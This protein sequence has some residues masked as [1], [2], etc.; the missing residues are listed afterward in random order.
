MSNKYS[1]V[2]E[3]IKGLKHFNIEE[4]GKPRMVFGG[5]YGRTDTDNRLSEF[6]GRKLREFLL[7]YL[8]GLSTEEE[9]MAEA[10]DFCAVIK[11]VADRSIE[12]LMAEAIKRRDEGKPTIVAVNSHKYREIS[13]E[14]QRLEGPY[15]LFGLID[16][17]KCPRHRVGTNVDDI[18]V[19]ITAMRDYTVKLEASINAYHELE[20]RIMDEARSTEAH[21]VYMD[22]MRVCAT[23]RGKF[24]D[25]NLFTLLQARLALMKGEPL[26]SLSKKSLT[27]RPVETA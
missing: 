24:N 21:P 20:G 7:N 25:V 14:I 10:K 26:K 9:L 2:E 8:V 18:S 19:E 6:M 4:E 23:I 12:T 11:T 3:V 16:K 5:C 22:G 17:F 13:N 1:L 15:S 27:I